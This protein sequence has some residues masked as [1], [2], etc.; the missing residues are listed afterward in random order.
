MGAW[1]KKKFMKTVRQRGHGGLDFPSV[2]FK[3]PVKA[4]E[5]IGRA[6]R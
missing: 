1:M 6:P 4:P 3:N 2:H 5:G